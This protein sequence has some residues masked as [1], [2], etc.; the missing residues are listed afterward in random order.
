MSDATTP[1][2]AYRALS[3]AAERIGRNNYV[4]GH[5]VSGSRRVRRYTPTSAHLRVVESMYAVMDGSIT[6]EQAMGVL[7]E[8]EVLRENRPGVL[9]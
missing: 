5:G 6:P 4:S 3:A 1:D 7:W 9:I 2:Q 8:S